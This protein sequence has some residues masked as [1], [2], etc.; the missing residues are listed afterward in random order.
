MGETTMGVEEE[1]T[2]ITE[3]RWTHGGKGDEEWEIGA[4]LHDDALALLRPRVV[5]LVWGVDQWVRLL[6][7]L[8][9]LTHRCYALG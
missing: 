8:Y 9:E 6:V 3:N 2:G 7:F 5:L 4:R 1:A